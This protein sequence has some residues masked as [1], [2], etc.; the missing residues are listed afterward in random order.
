MIVGVKI[1]NGSFDPDHAPFRG[2]LFSSIGAN[3]LV[4][5]YCAVCMIVGVKTENGSFDPDHAPFR[6]GLF[7]S[8]GANLLV[9]QYCAV[10][11]LTHVC[12]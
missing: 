2:G 11:V 4:K 10:F 9:K 6:G 3:L 7:S 1:E 5:Q 8:I 12:V